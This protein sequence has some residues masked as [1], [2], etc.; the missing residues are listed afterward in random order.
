MKGV[1]NNMMIDPPDDIKRDKCEDYDKL[2]QAFSLKNTESKD[3]KNTD[4]EK[5]K[6]VKWMLFNL[7]F[8][9][10]NDFHRFTEWSRG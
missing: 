2:K 5:E 10:V 7:F 9:M 6:V 8:D 1:L 4:R 3:K